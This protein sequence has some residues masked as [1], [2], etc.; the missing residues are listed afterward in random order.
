MPTIPPVM[1]GDLPALSFQSAQVPDRGILG[2]IVN[3]LGDGV[4]LNRRTCG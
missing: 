3:R 4:H 1:N 2:S